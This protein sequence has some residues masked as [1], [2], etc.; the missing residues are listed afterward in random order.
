MKRLI[1]IAGLAILL[2][3]CKNGGMETNPYPDGIYPFEVANISHTRGESWDYTVTWDNPSDNGFKD[4]QVEIYTIMGT[5]E[6]NE[7][8]M[9]SSATGEIYDLVL[10][11]PVLEKSR[12]LFTAARADKFLIIKCADKYGNISKGVKYEFL[13]DRS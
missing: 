10:Q 6:Y 12:L 9:Y 2:L 7:L 1:F 3:S 4:V 13:D 11:N 8:L 5:V